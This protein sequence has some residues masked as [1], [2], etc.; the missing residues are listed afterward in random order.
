M[1]EPCKK[2]CINKDVKVFRKQNN[3]AKSK[4]SPVNNEVLIRR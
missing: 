3:Q 1:T 4:V 2:K